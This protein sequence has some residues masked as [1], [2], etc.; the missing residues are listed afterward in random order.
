ML[1]AELNCDLGESDDP[2][3]QQL[4]N[5]LLP[6]VTSVNVACGAH[7]GSF[8]R[9]LQI[10]EL[11]REFRTAFG[12]HPSFPDR[13]GFGRRELQLPPEILLQSL[14]AQIQLA[15]SAAAHARIPLAHIKPH[16]ALYNM[17]ADHREIAE[18]VITAIQQTAPSAALITLASSPLVHHARHA[19]LTVRQEFFADRAYS[20]DGKL[21][22]RQ[23][24]GSLITNPTTITH[25][26]H[27]LLNDQT[28]TTTDGTLLT[29]TADT[30]CIHS[31]TPDALEIVKHIKQSLNTCR[32]N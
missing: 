32:A 20:A 12:A 23:L 28:V 16:G 30:I 14:I 6:L 11:C 22:S 24:P 8:Q 18:L 7:A 1:T 26:I 5:Q 27:Q 29:I 21:L 15:Q 31:D 9:L 13:E 25:R 2:A 3:G 19:G 4:E 10:A 17:A